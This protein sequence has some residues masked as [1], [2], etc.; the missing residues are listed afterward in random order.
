MPVIDWT[1]PLGQIANGVILIVGFTIAVLKLYHA[2]DKRT[3]LSAALASLRLD[4][5][6]RWRLVVRKDMHE[7]SDVLAGMTVELKRLA[8]VIEERT[9]R[10]REPRNQ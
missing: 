3:S 4:E 2:L 6:E 8:T 10:R 5:L 9:E 1:I 7:V